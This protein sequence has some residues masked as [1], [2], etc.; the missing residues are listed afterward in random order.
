M[1]L[2]GTRGRRRPCSLGVPSPEHG[3]RGQ[4]GLLG[5]RE[6]SLDWLPGWRPVS[7]GQLGWPW[8]H[9]E[10]DLR[11]AGGSTINLGDWSI[12]SRQMF[13]HRRSGQATVVRGAGRGTRRCGFSDTNQVLWCRKRVQGRPPGLYTDPGPG[14]Y[15][16]GRAEREPR[17]QQPWHSPAAPRPA[18]GHSPHTQ[19]PRTAAFPT[20]AGLCSAYLCA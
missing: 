7:G 8:G 13:R 20:D 10:G 11:S 12:S 18:Q 15:Q 5:T 4:R 9:P 3:C 14:P 1:S 16:P 6:A 17:P 2:L 19:T